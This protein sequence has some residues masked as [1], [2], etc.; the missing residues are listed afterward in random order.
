[1]AQRQQDD[2]ISLLTKIRGDTQTDGQTHTDIQTDSKVIADASFLAYI[3]IL[4][5]V[6]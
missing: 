4:K 6:Q 3:P 2:L 1:M 5:K